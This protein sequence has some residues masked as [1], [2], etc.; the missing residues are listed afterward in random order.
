MPSTRGSRC[1][2]REDGLAVRSTPSGRSWRSPAKP[3]FSS[4][5]YG[6]R[7]CGAALPR[8]GVDPPTRSA[9]CYCV[10]QHRQSS[11]SRWR[12]WGAKGSFIGELGASAALVV[13]GTVLVASEVR[14]NWLSGLAADVGN[15]PNLDTVDW[16]SL[17]AELKGRGLLDKPG[18]GV[19]ALKWHKAGKIDYEQGGRIPVISL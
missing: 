9:G 7:W 5:G 10:W 15:Q 2:S 1:C 12:G 16:T 4:P 6:C 18:L 17:Q 3:R 14:F 8:R 11:C 19:A 13:L